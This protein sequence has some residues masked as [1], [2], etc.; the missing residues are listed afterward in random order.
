MDGWRRRLSRKKFSWSIYSRSASKQFQQYKTIHPSIACAP[1]YYHNRLPRHIPIARFHQN[2]MISV[3]LE[4]TGTMM[5]VVSAPTKPQKVAVKHKR[6]FCKVEGCIR[7][8]KSQGTCQRHGA[9][10]RECKIVGCLKQAQGGFNGMCKCHARQ[11]EAAYAAGEPSGFQEKI[12][13]PAASLGAAG[14]QQQ[15]YTK[16]APPPRQRRVCKIDSC[17]RIVKSQGLCQRHGAIPTKC[18]IVGCTKQAQGNYRRMCKAHYRQLGQS[19][20]PFPVDQVRLCQPVQS[21]DCSTPS[22]KDV[23]RVLPSDDDVSKGSNSGG[24]TE[25]WYDPTE[26]DEVGQEMLDGSFLYDSSTR[27]ED[28][29]ADL[30]N[31]FEAP[32]NIKSTTPLTT[33][34]SSSSSS[35]LDHFDHGRRNAHRAGAPSCALDQDL[36]DTLNDMLRDECGNESSYAEL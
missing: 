30:A 21:C 5:K 29:A 9:K 13:A 22:G 2:L 33:T 14:A 23:H 35:F 27:N 12:P 19:H 1:H 36:L 15:E 25:A 8:V 10:P 24:T 28:L 26:G 17:D 3:V 34:T 6:R 11:V 20:S 31:L 4:P 16:M 18:I 32:Q 7:I